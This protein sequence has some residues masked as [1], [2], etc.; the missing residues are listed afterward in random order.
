M[1]EP[2]VQVGKRYYVVIH[3]YH[4]IIG[5]LQTITGKREGD[6]VDVVWVYKSDQHWDDFFEK[7]DWSRTT[8]RLWPNGNT[9]WIAAFEFPHD[10]PTEKGRR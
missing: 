3:A 1:P 4:H 2:I 8:Y 9:S 7:P 6:F 10:I 5:T